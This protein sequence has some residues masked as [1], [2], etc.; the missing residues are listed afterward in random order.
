MRHSLRLFFI[1]F[2]LWATFTPATAQ[3]TFVQT[4]S[5]GFDATPRVSQRRDAARLTLQSSL[6]MPQPDP[7]GFFSWLQSTEVTL[8]DPVKATAGYLYNMYI[9][10]A[11][12][13]ETPKRLTLSWLGALD[14]LVM[15]ESYGRADLTPVYNS[16]KKD[17]KNELAFLF[18]KRLHI[19]YDV[20]N[21]ANDTLEHA[22]LQTLKNSTAN[23]KEA[24]YIFGPN[25]TPNTVLTPD[26]KQSL[27]E[28]VQK[29]CLQSDDL[30]CKYQVADL[31]AGLDQKRSQPAM[32][33]YYRS[34]KEEC[35]ACTYNLCSYICQKTQTQFADWKLLRLYQ[36]TVRPIAS[37]YIRPAQGDGFTSVEGKK[38]PRWAYH[39]AT[40]LALEYDNQI[41][42]LVADS[43]LYK[44]PVLLDQWAAMFKKDQT[45]FHV[46]PFRR[47]Q[48]TEA[49][50]VQV[51]DTQ[52]QKQKNNMTLNMGSKIYLPYP[53]EK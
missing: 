45:F 4:L 14:P 7:N 26:L 36:I 19:H 11:L 10:T 16:S 34:I 31:G 33:Q 50:F 23:G 41:I 9:N 38:Y 15:S 2:L 21:P 53:V 27:Q 8:N 6:T 46:Q 3:Q 17:V 43:F 52:R 51:P 12:G 25:H 22:F 49:G 48:Q 39:T 29:A 18:Q 1:L 24:G 20:R 5:A 47:S 13:K 32:T 44:Q 35:A 40:L 37:A 28:T 30:I 42:Y